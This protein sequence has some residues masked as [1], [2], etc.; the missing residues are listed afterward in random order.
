MG[1]LCLSDREQSSEDSDTRTELESELSPWPSWTACRRPAA[2]FCKPVTAKVG[3]PFLPAYLHV[4]F[5]NAS[6][7]FWTVKGY[8]G[9]RPFSLV[10][11]QVPCGGTCEPGIDWLALV[12]PLLCKK[13]IPVLISCSFLINHRLPAA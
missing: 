7:E 3:A 13:L 10:I 6:Q 12:C 8:R 5:L 11:L 1:G 4:D 9:C 2:S